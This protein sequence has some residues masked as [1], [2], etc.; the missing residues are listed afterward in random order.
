MQAANNAQ[1]YADC[2][3]IRPLVVVPWLSEDQLLSLEK[4]RI[5]GV[6][7]CG[8]GVLVAPGLSVFRTGT[9]NKFPASRPLKRV[10]DGTSALVGRVFLL[11][12]EYNSVSEIREEV[13]AR[14]GTITL[15]TVLR[16]VINKGKQWE[17]VDCENPATGITKFKLKHRERFVYAEELPRLIAAIEAEENQ[18]IKDYVLISLYTG[19]RKMNVLKMRW[20]DVDLDNAVWTIPDTKNNTAQT[21]LLTGPELEILQKRFDNRKKF[22]YVF[23][24]TGTKSPHLADPKK[25]WHRILKRARIENLHLHDLRRTLGSYMAMTGASLSVIGNALNHKDVSTT[26][27]VYAHSAHEAERTARE[28]AHQRMFAKQEEKENKVVPLDKSRSNVEF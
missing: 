6:D 2:L 1:F 24:G 19:A 23:P 20:A 17:L 8:N 11:K 25:G 10:Y 15:S 26:R 13:L 28:V 21:I 4:R 18:E 16:A 12:P 5:S 22:D 14:G 7:L 9:R 27:K 3:N